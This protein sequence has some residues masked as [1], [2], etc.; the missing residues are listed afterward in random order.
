MTANVSQIMLVF[1]GVQL[2]ARFAEES[3]AEKEGGCKKGK[4]LCSMELSPF[5]SFTFIVCKGASHSYRLDTY[6]ALAF[7]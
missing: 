2:K 1:M 5:F 3:N 6:I 4:E 7:R